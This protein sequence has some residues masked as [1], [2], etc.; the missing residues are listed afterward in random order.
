VK[1]FGFIFSPEG[2]QSD[3]DKTAVIQAYP[4][5]RQQKYVRS[6]LGLTNYFRRYIKGYSEICYPLYR[7]LRKDVRFVWTQV[8]KTV[9]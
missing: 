5:P 8:E 2:A 4:V 9:F 6:F 1:Y 7:L 3:P